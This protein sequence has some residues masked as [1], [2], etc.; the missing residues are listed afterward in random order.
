LNPGPGAGA[1]LKLVVCDEP[2]SALDMSV[3]AQ[4]L[5]L[6]RELR[7]HMG[8]SYLFI[9]YH[10]GVVEYIADRVAVMRVGAIVEQGACAGVLGRPAHEYTR[11]LLA[12]VL[13]VV[14]AWSFACRRGPWAPL[15]AANGGPIRCLGMY[16]QSAPQSS[17]AVRADSLDWCGFARAHAG[18]PVA[19]PTARLGGFPG[20]NTVDGH[21][22]IELH[23]I[24]EPKHRVY[25]TGAG[26]AWRVRVSINRRCQES[27]PCSRR[28]RFARA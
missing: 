28:P 19:P 25:K 22:T 12:A 2:T 5:N 4:V 27:F 3:Q 1:S 21:L 16:P 9:T 6:L 14:P 8:L 24:A 13:R 20:P 18:H 23:N 17:G 15:P 10:I 7:L 26:L 11:A